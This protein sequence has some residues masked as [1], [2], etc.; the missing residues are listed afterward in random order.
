ME[1]SI[2][3]LGNKT[4][5]TSLSPKRLCKWRSY[6][7]VQP[8]SQMN[9]IESVVEIA[10]KSAANVSESKTDIDPQKDWEI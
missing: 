2:F 5:M 10:N 1:I 4:I 3:L 6:D 7:D 8:K 9:T